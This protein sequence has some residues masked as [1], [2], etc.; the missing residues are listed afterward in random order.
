MPPWRHEFSVQQLK[1]V[2]AYVLSREFPN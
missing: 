2:V 1:A